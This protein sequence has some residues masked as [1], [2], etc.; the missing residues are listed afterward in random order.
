MQTL[1]RLEAESIFLRK[2]LSMAKVTR[3]EAAA[4]FS[5][6]PACR[7]LQAYDA[8]VRELQKR[9][10]DLELRSIAEDCL[11]TVGDNLIDG[12]C[13]VDL[14]GRVVSINRSYAQLTEATDNEVVG[15]TIHDLL[16][17]GKMRVAVTPRVMQ[18]K[19]KISVLC[20]SPHLDKTYLITG[21]PLFDKNG[22]L[23]GAMTILRDMTEITSIAN[24]L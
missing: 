21:L 10:D 2:A 8:Q 11:L 18:E 16:E 23:K 20:A 15:H 7:L 3:E 24:T 12:I 6:D 14:Q 17:T 4:L 22:S 1:T 5:S 13:V 19:K 9:I